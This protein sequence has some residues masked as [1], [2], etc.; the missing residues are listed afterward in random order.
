MN[1]G[2][3]VTAG[4]SRQQRFEMLRNSLLAASGWPRAK[5]ERSRINRRA[6]ALSADAVKTSPPMD[7][8][9]RSSGRKKTAI[10]PETITSLGTLSDGKSVSIIGPK[11]LADT[12]TGWINILVVGAR[13]QHRF[14]WN[15][16][17]FSRCRDSDALTMTALEEIEKMIDEALQ[18]CH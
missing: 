13:R 5:D 12:E 8:M 3:S 15:G 1:D 4:S 11:S 9:L 6:W 14:G 17:R 2:Q 16:K 18:R 10:D 7:G